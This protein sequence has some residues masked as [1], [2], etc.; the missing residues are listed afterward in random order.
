MGRDPLAFLT[1]CAREYGDFVPLRL[2]LRRGFLL[3]HPDLIEE[4]LVT[5]QRNFVKSP[6]VRRLRVLGNGLVSS[7]GGFW[8][9]QRR[10]MQ[11]AFHRRRIAAYGEAMVALTERML[12]G[13]TA[14]SGAA[15]A[16]AGATA[17]ARAAG[18]EGQGPDGATGGWR[19]GEARDV[20]PEM[21]GLTMAIVTRTLFGA[22][23]PAAAQGIGPAL[24]EIGE[25][26]NSRI[27]SLLFWLPDWVPTPGNLRV[28]R[29]IRRLDAVIYSLIGRAAAGDGSGA[30]GDDLLS[31][32][33]H[34]QDE[35]GSRMTDRQLRDEVMTLF[36]A[37]HDT[38]SLALSWT[39][40]LLAQ[41]P[42]AEARLH[43]ELA[44]VLGDRAPTVADLPRLRYAEHVIT[45]ALRLYPPVWAISREALADCRIGGRHVPRGSLLT[46]SPW[47]LHRDSRFFDEPEE[48]RPERW[49]ES[50]IE[51]E[52]LTADSRHTPAKRLPRFAFFPF[53]GGPRVCIGNTFA[54]MEAVLVLAT[55]AQRFR[56]T[57]VPGHPVVPQPYVTLRPRSGIKMVLHRR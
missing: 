6:A 1:Q 54:M 49:A 14:P 15:G 44:E 55:I 48:Y 3:N 4:V 8:R 19:D 7:E 5:Q 31:L 39:W 35:D 21:M 47:V 42:Q 20:L 22:D 45:E 17:G 36:L 18:A 52:G 32:L 41:H 11:P 56:L 23:V 9:R 53:G 43:A 27:Y 40:Y 37:G 12:D 46:I 10:L 38:T 50:P 34:A 26:F 25:H 16:R 51:S 33:L 57:A 24:T 30:G 2:G 29:A 13:P 28:A